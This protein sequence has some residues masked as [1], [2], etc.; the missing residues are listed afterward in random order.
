MM[1][2][3]HCDEGSTLGHPLSHHRDKRPPLGH[4]T[5]CSKERPDISSH[6]HPNIWPSPASRYMVL[7]SFLL[8]ALRS[9]F[10]GCDS[11]CVVNT[12]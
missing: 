9:I 7:A 4:I 3:Q 12:P 8:I 2:E 5:T 11:A 10:I 1:F 6:E